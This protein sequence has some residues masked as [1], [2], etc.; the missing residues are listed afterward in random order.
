[1]LVMP[2][3]VALFLLQRFDVVIEAL[4]KGQAVDLSGFPPSPG[5]GKET[6]V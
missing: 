6:L 1:M 4:E 3:I 5:Q 2:T